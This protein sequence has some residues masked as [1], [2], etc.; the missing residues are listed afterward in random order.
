[1]TMI[2]HD[3]EYKESKKHKE[4]RNFVPK[5]IREVLFDSQGGKCIYCGRRY[6]L[7]N[8]IADHKKPVN[9]EGANKIENIQLICPACNKYKG[10]MTDPEFRRKYRLPTAKDSNHL[11]PE[12]VLP[13]HYFEQISRARG[14]AKRRKHKLAHFRA[15]NKD[16]YGQGEY[17]QDEHTQDE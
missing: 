4:K 14:V 7:G 3:L 5:E 1:M 2:D 6:N 11:P 12:D 13:Q 15:R 16:E 10:R 9:R 17:A 8:F